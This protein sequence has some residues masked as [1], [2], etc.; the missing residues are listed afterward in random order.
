MIVFQQK[1]ESLSNQNNNSV[2]MSIRL[3][4]INLTQ[5]LF[6]RN[7]FLIPNSSFLIPLSHFVTYHL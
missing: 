3:R 2:T 6:W 4:S 1:S 7:L 5:H